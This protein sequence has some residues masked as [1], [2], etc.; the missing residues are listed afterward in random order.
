ML[1]IPINK[2][3]EAIRKDPIIKKHFIFFDGRSVADADVPGLKIATMRRL[4]H[5][6]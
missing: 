5:I 6:S 3:R 2:I 4:I 1:Q